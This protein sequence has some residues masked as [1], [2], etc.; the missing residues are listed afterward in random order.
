MRTTFLK[1]SKIINVSMIKKTSDMLMSCGLRKGSIELYT[2]KGLLE[3]QMILSTLIVDSRYGHIEMI[4]GIS[5]KDAMDT[6]N[7]IANN[8]IH[9]DDIATVVENMCN[10]DA[11][12]QKAEY[13]VNKGC[14]VPVKDIEQVTNEVLV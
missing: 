4:C 11:I 1:E 8:K 7:F 10:M 14:F 5:R 13:K 9:F 12:N 6:A 2:S 3:V